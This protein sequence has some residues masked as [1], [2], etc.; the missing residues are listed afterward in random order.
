MSIR[1]LS[2]ALL[3]AALVLP[4]AACAQTQAAQAGPQAGPTAGARAGHHRGGGWR[5]ALRGITLTDQ[6]KQQLK[7]AAAQMR[8]SNQTADPQTRRANAQKFRSTVEG[9]LTPAQRTQFEQNLQQMRQRHARRGAAP[10]P[11]ATPQA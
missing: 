4:T 8:Q 3:G 9:I 5:G 2:T 10:A 1:F 11:A 6:Q 7:D